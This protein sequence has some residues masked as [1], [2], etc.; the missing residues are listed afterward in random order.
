MPDGLLDVSQIAVA[1]KACVE[2]DAEMR[3]RT[4]KLIVGGGSGQYPR[5]FQGAVQVRIVTTVLEPEIQRGRE[6]VQAFLVL[7][8]TGQRLLAHRD[9]VVKIGVLPGQAESGAE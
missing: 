4:W 7:I 9:G 8:G 3:K 1:D 5:E 2:H 6:A